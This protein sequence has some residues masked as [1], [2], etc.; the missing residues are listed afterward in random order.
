MLQFSTQSLPEFQWERMVSRVPLLGY[1]PSWLE[2]LGA[3]RRKQTTKGYF[4]EIDGKFS[5]I[6]QAH[7]RV[8]SQGKFP[9][10]VTS[11]PPLS[12]ALEP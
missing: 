10:R 2:V 11:F 3:T 8:L 12:S 4:R 5:E 1:S 6:I 9:P 7:W